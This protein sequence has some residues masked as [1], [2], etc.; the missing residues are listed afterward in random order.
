MAGWAEGRGET[1]DG[2]GRQEL[3]EGGFVGQIL[4][5]DERPRRATARRRRSGGSVDPMPSR[6]VT[7]SFIQRRAAWRALRPATMG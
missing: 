4:P 7:L 5:G 6:L 3:V 2:Y 1:G